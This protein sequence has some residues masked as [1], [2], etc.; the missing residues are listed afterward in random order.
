MTLPAWNL[1]MKQY[2]FRNPTKTK[3]AEFQLQCLSSATRTSRRSIRKLVFF[4]EVLGEFWGV[5]KPWVYQTTTRT[6]I[7]Y[8]IHTSYCGPVRPV[9]SVIFFL[10]KF[11][12]WVVSVLGF[13]K[14]TKGGRQQKC[15]S[16]T[17]HLTRPNDAQQIQQIQHLVRKFSTGC[18]TKKKRCPKFPTARNPRFVPLHGNPSQAAMGRCGGQLGWGRPGQADGK[19]PQGK[20]CRVGS[21]MFKGKEPQNLELSYPPWNFLYNIKPLQCSNKPIQKGMLLWSFFVFGGEGVWLVWILVW[22]QPCFFPNF[23]FV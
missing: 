11:D 22:I 21:V 15:K 7:V 20:S 5:S 23:G 12:A 14:V 17:T 8:Q 9:I 1:K 13:S 4:L 16:I 3:L 10:E 6:T 2:T 18:P 19:M